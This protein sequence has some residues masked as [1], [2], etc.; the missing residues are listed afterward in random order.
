[1]HQDR[2]EF[3]T[4]ASSISGVDSDYSCSSTHLLIVGS[5]ECGDS[6]STP[7]QLIDDS[8]ST[9]TI[10]STMPESTTMPHDVLVVEREDLAWKTS[11]LEIEIC[12][13][14]VTISPFFMN[15]YI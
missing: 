1:M 14:L 9:Q 2:H 15:L 13:K 8:G 3:D 5:D 7:S 6:G 12:I 4:M 10:I 11:T